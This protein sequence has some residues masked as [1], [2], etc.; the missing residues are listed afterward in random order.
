MLLNLITAAVGVHSPYSRINGSQ[1]YYLISPVTSRIPN[2]YLEWGDCTGGKRYDLGR[3]V[4]SH[5]LPASGVPPNSALWYILPEPACNDGLPATQ[6]FYHI[7]GA[8]ATTQ[9]SRML[10]FDYRGDVYPMQYCRR[11]SSGFSCDETYLATEMARARFR[12]E[13]V[14]HESQQPFAD[15]L[16]Y[17]ITG[18]D[19]GMPNEMIFLN[20]G[21]F[22]SGWLDTWTIDLNDNQATWRIVP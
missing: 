16:Y 6:C 2:K 1:P 9:P 20:S 12:V 8:V 19:S 5:V 11:A 21:A 4:Q 14:S 7:L 17:I 15:E 22:T 13:A 18:P 3:C 10:N